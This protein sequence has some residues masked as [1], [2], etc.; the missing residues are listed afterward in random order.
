MSP[1]K[2]ALRLLG[3]NFDGIQ[4]SSRVSLGAHK[5]YICAAVAAEFGESKAPIVEW[6]GKVKEVIAIFANGRKSKKVVRLTE[7]LFKELKFALSIYI[8]S[9]MAYLNGSSPFLAKMNSRLASCIDD[10][11]GST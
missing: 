3:Y 7:E 6:M 8:S 1:K 5:P 4:G 9:Q 11:F 2:P 10:E